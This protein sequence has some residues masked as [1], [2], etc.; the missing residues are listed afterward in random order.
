MRGF[1]R[2]CVSLWQHASVVCLAWSSVPVKWPFCAARS[3]GRRCL[4]GADCCPL[5]HSVPLATSACSLERQQVPGTLHR[6]RNLCRK[7]QP[8]LSRWPRVVWRYSPCVLVL[9][10]TDAL[11]VAR[12]FAGTSAHPTDQESGTRR[13]A[14]G[15]NF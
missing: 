6:R 15:L 13:A 1:L 5:A 8:R 4:A 7:C 2:S 12:S 3:R 10:P 9:R 11:C 14:C